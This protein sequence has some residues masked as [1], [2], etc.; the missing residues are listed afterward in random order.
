MGL[1]REGKRKTKKH[2]GFF[3]R[4]FNVRGKPRTFESGKHKDTETSKREIQKRADGWRANRHFV[5]VTQ[6]K[7]TGKNKDKTVHRLWVM[8]DTKST[9]V[10]KRVPKKP[11]SRL[12]RA[13]G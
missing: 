10:P 8:I 1:R 12:R 13:F 4:K 6:E 2:S 5:R 7:G 3:Y 9:P 11:K